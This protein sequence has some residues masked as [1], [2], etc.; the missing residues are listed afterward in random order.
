MDSWN[1][2]RVP[3]YGLGYHDRDDLPF[4]YAMADSWTIGDQY[5]QSTLTETI[6]N[7]LVALSGSNGLSVNSS[8]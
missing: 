5:F 6:P 1:T 4:Y 7:R 3:G 2:E 8:L